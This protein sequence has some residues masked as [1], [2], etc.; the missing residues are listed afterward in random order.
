[1]KVYRLDNPWALLFL[2]FPTICLIIYFTSRFI[3]K[4]GV[5]ITG[6]SCFEKGFSIFPFFYFL[7]IASII[8]GLYMITF[9]LTNPQYGIKKEKI[10]TEGIDIMISLDISGSMTIKDF[11][12]QSRIEG[13][14]GILEKF[15]D[16]R[17]GDR[18]GL[19]TFADSSFLKCPATINYNLLKS[20]IKKIQ[21]ELNRKTAIGIGLSSAIN[22]ILKVKNTTEQ[23]SKIIILLTDGKNNTGEIS[24]EA[25]TEIASITGIK[26]YT[27]GIGEKEEIDFDLLQIMANNTGG[28]FFH[29]KTSGELGN[30]FEDIDKIEKHKIETIDFVRF[31][32]VGYKFATI[33]IFFLFTGI[34]LNTF[35]FKKLS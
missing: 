32:N 16:K 33:G 27:I 28:K 30:I 13:A 8:F 7:S 12:K 26:I 23:V 18:I 4:K 24:P 35:L 5:K 31:N 20:V 19:V 14:K 10:I 1:M 34:I 11:L 17:K 6:V 2:I 29:A 25:A 21:I 15:I 3:Y 9:S 22:R